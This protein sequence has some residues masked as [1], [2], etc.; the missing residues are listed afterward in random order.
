MQCGTVPIFAQT[1][2]E[3]ITKSEVKMRGSTLQGTLMLKTIRP[4]WSRE[5]KINI[6]MKGDDYAMIRVQSPEK[7]KGITFLKRSKELW[8]WIPAIDK[9]IK[10]PPSMMSQ[11]WMGT[12]FSN[13][14][15]VKES[16]LITD[17]DA[18]FG[19]D[20][21]IDGRECWKVILIPKE[22]AAVVWGKVILFIDKSGY[23]QLFGEY[24]NEDGELINSVRGTNIQK[25]GGRFIPTVFEM[26]PNDKPGNKTVLTYASVT[27]DLLIDDAFFTIQNMKQLQ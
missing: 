15:L 5:M 25:M 10:L 18:A 27:F 17:F 7:D 2:S 8:N 26:I 24:F 9:T 13:D 21:I 20:S 6:W 23:L 1:A 12:D 16:S 4:S 11:S 22:L 3:V 14:Y 19:K